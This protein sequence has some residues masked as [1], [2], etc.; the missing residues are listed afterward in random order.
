MHYIIRHTVIKQHIMTN[1]DDETQ[2]NEKSNACA[3][4]TITKTMNEGQPQ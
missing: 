3:R 2:V 4:R 1:D